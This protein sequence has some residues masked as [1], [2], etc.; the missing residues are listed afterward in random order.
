MRLE[1]KSASIKS[2]SECIQ[3]SNASSF[4]ICTLWRDRAAQLS[5]APRWRAVLHDADK[6]ERKGES[7]E[8][9]APLLGQGELTLGEVDVVIGGKQSNQAD[10]S[11]N[12]GCQQGFAVEPKPPLGRRGIQIP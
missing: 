8:P 9:D 5:V 11:A 7:D 6:N 4:S 3:L 2:I 10:N 1:G 12:K